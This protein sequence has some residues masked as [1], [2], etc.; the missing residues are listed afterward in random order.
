MGQ[1]ADLVELIG[2]EPDE[3]LLD[4]G[5]GKLPASV[6]RPESIQQSPARKRVVAIGATLT[7]VTLVLGT[8]LAAFGAVDGLAT[9]FDAGAILAL[10]VGVILVSTHWGWVHVAEITGQKLERSA[11][12]EPLERRERWLQAIEPY[13]RWEVRTDLGE[14]GSITI[15]T[16]RYKPAASGERRFTFAREV[17]AQE[18]HSGEEP[19][20]VVTERAEL[21]RRQAAADTDR[22]RRL[23][24]AG[25]AAYESARLAHADEQERLDAVRAASRALSEQIN[26][27]LREPPLVE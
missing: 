23:Y 5:L 8:V 11:N 2:L 6:G 15:V 22:E 13:T 27:N 16:T 19:A 14:D 26:A 7:G 1:E 25:H 20:A 3:R 4:E 21:V 24:E 12:R 17:V 10:I 9:G 18:R